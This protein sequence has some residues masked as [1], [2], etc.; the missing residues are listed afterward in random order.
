[1][2]TVYKR[3]TELLLRE[4]K[5]K[6]NPAKRR[7]DYPRSQRQRSRMAGKRIA[8]MRNRP[9]GKGNPSWA[10]WHEHD[11]TETWRGPEQHKTQQDID[12][13]MGGRPEL[14]IDRHAAAQKER[15]RE[16][17]PEGAKYN[18]DKQEAEERGIPFHIFRQKDLHQH[19]RK[20]AERRIGR[21]KK[22]EEGT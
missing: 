7:P 12:R 1:M 6:Y 15:E 5:G 4:A 2:D 14:S 21:R 11:P 9:G 16:D 10:K 20:A 3:M 22:R 8:A 18:R 13:M 17:T 19:D